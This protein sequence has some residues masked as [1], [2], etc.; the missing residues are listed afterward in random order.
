MNPCSPPL[1]HVRGTNRAFGTSRAAPPDASGRA[2]I[3][4]S[5]LGTW[6]RLAPVGL[7]TP[8]E[9]RMTRRKKRPHQ[10]PPSSAR[11]TS[12]PPSTGATPPTTPA[13][14]SRLD[15]ALWPSLFSDPLPPYASEAVTSS[16]D[17]L[18][19]NL[20][21]IAS[22]LP[23]NAGNASV[24]PL[25]LLMREAGQPTDDA[26]NR[27][28]AVED[29]WRELERIQE[30]RDA[31]AEL[32]VA[33]A[34]VAR[35]QRQ[36]ERAQKA[37]ERAAEIERRRATGGLYANE[38]RSPNRPCH[39]EVAPAAWAAVKRE[40][41]R[42]QVPVGRYVGSLVADVAAHGLPHVAA[43]PQVGRTRRFTRL[44]AVDD[45]TWTAFRI[46]ADEAGFTTALTLGLV[47]EVEARRL[48][49]SKERS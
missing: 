22:E 28:G 31:A 24:D 30:L 33:E 44:L 32:R 39:A 1:W 34:A 7:T 38:K 5:D 2:E 17:R 26:A 47:V 10:N 15:D 48:G 9:A 21:T 35:K 36:L 25:D 43:A 19:P 11:R 16:S 40:A 27:R 20:H 4:L 41:I 37:R 49:W 45:D 23:G 6:T 14:Q 12:P 13:P 18:L 29:L 8:W 46:R 3:A 42:R